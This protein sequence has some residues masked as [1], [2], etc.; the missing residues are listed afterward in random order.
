MDTTLQDPLVGRVLDGRYHVESRLAR[1]GMATVYLALD[2]RL[3]RMVAVKVMHPQ[4]AEDQE[5]VSRFIREAKA[6]ARL[7]HPNVVAVFD[8]GADDGVV[9]LA[10][11]LVAGRTLRDLMREHGRISPRQTLEILESVLAALGAAHHAG[12]V[13]RDV[14]PENV[15]LADDGRVKV[16]D[17][18]LAR[19]VSGAT[20]HTSTGSVL[21][22]TVAY[23]SPEQVERGV[24]DPRSDVY[25]VG[26]LL[27]EMLTGEK[28]YDGETAIQVAYRH[29]H[30]D[31]PPPSTLVG[32]LPAELDALVARATSRD[33]DGRP[34]DARRFLAEVTQ[35]RRGLSDAELDVTARPTERLAA[36]PG[37][38]EHT[39]VVP[40]PPSADARRSAR[41]GDTG[42]LPSLRRHGGRRGWIALLL[43]LLLAAGLSGAAWWVAAGP[44]AYTTAPSLLMLSQD[45]AAEK[46]SSLGFTMRVVGSEFD[47]RVAADHVL[48]TDPGPNERIRDDGTINVVLSKGPERYAVPNIRG[49]TEDEAKQ[50]LA[51]TNLS[52]GETERAYSD[53]VQKGLVISTDPVPGTRLKRAEAVGL[54]ISRGVQPVKVPDVVG[55]K[56]EDAERILAAAPLGNKVVE[57]HHDTVPAGVVISQAP[58][59]GK[60]PKNST[61]ELVVSKG[62]P[63]VPVPDVVSKPLAEAMQIMTA[64]GFTTRVFN[65]PG[66]PDRVLDQSPNAGDQAPKGSQVTLSVF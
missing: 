65:L 19:A 54:V 48:S 20:N 39:L 40:V 1:G 30:D 50:A 53:S 26:I 41:G 6:A 36:T 33:P 27:F 29:V 21:M 38:P 62:P 52:L 13:H 7:S 22:G 28:P 12:I 15:L 9:F 56:L 4:L 44:G 24:A 51:D 59:K 16:A 17:F 25:A 11:E 10:M 35:V 31:V 55:K 5:F 46:A 61:V 43:V 23:L 45:E 47:E 2:S 42:P 66:G 8:Q 14:K 63:P 49:K 64:A 58:A 57:K 18:G 32:G 34:D 60:A 37:R 3:D